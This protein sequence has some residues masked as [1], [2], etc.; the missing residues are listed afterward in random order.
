MTMQ[1]N[2]KWVQLACGLMGTML[3][4]P[5][6]LKYL[7]EDKLLKQLSECFVELETVSDHQHVVRSDL[8]LMAETFQKQRI[9]VS[10]EGGGKPDVWIL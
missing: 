2:H 5:E 4:T 3:A 1:P 10:R 9:P 7:G 8:Q 6:G